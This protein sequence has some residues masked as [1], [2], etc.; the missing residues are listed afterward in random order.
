MIGCNRQSSHFCKSS[1]GRVES[2]NSQF[3]CR[4]LTQRALPASLPR[5]FQGVVLPRAGT[6][7]RNVMLEFFGSA[8]KKLTSF[9]FIAA[10]AII[11]VGLT[12]LEPLQ[13]ATPSEFFVY[14]VVTFGAIFLL[15]VFHFV[16]VT[17][18]AIIKVPA[19]A[20]IF[21]ISLCFAYIT[22]AIT[23]RAFGGPWQPCIILFDGDCRD[24]SS[25]KEDVPTDSKKD[26]YRGLPVP[27]LGL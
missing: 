3:L 9:P 8:A 27:S 16:A 13:N 18:I 25:R 20:L 26:R 4:G 7:W 1:T 10:L 14:L 2:W 24:Y 23:S 19:V 21:I 15:I 12:K 17:P 11:A 6:E 5:A 22:V